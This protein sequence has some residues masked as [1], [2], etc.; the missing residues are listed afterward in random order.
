MNS[1]NGQ[2]TKDMDLY[3]IPK[4]EKKK[5]L[6]EIKKIKK[7]MNRKEEQKFSDVIEE[8]KK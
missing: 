2:N 4:K 5:I 6:K 8:A 7:M 1:H 3:P